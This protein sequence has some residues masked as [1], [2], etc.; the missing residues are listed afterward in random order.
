MK[1]FKATSLAAAALLV[2]SCATESHKQAAPILLQ[3][4]HSPARFEAV[5][6]PRVSEAGEVTAIAVDSMVYGGLNEGTDRLVLRAPV[7]FVGAYGIADRMSD[8]A[9]TDSL[10]SVDLEISEDEPG[11]GGFGQFRYWTAQREVSFPVRIQY[12]TAVE[13]PTDRRGPPFNIKQSSAGVSGAGAAFLLLPQ[14]VDSGFSRVR[15]DLREFKEFASGIS[16]WGTGEFELAGGP[17]ALMNGWYMA[18]PMGRYPEVGDERGFSASWLGDYSFDPEAEMRWVGEAY[19]WLADYFGYMSPP[20]RFRVFMR[21]IASKLT[22]FSGTVLGQSFMLSGGPNSGESTDGAAPRGTFI[23]EMIHMWVGQVQAPQ[24]ISSWFSEGLTS[25]YSLVLPVRAGYENL[26][27][28]QQGINQ[29]A[30]NYFT[31]PGIAMSAEAI[32]EVGFTNE[33]IRRTPYYRGAMYFADLDAQLRRRSAGKRDLNA[34][35]QEIFERRHNDADFT[36]DHA[37]WKDTL[38]AELGPE[39]VAEF[40][41]RVIDGVPFEPD[42]DAFGPCFERVPASYSA[43]EAGELEEEVS[44]FRWVRKPEM[45]DALCIPK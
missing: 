38:T 24:G 22:H 21:I 25:Y 26:D 42:S 34:V 37:A 43:G 11:Q 10:G 8:I 2:A 14:A 44:G 12:E 39:A 30:E 9:V 29:L 3:G 20:P 1:F 4:P 41:K 40:D 18:G 35:M 5:L 6:Q 16:S 36:F 19:H 32:T 27:E 33:F 45:D 13:P 31:S 23:H 7:V 28:Y 17:D 15:W